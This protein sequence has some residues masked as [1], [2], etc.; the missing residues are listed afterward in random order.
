MPA[1]ENV[2]IDGCLTEPR[3]DYIAKDP[4]LP[5]EPEITH[6]SQETVTEDPLL[7]GH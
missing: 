2:C 7:P 4:L 5:G 1:S 6:F 3:P